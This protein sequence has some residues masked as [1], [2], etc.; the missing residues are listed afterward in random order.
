MTR[1]ALETWDAASTSWIVVCTFP[2][3]AEARA[4]AWSLKLQ[5]SRVREVSAVS[6]T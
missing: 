1:F 6:R 2:T 4:R 5:H 3:K